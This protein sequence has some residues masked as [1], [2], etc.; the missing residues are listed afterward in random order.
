[1]GIVSIVYNILMHFI[2][3]LIFGLAISKKVTIVCRISLGENYIDL[4]IYEICLG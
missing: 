4:E 3:F 1:M 2:A